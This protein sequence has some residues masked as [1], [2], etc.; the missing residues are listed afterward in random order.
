MLANSQITE[1]LKH[2]PISSAR[3]KK[4]Y[5]KY[6]K[7]NG[8]DASEKKSE[9]LGLAMSPAGAAPPIRVLK[10]YEKMHEAL[11]SWIDYNCDTVFDVRDAHPSK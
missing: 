6:F 11:G 7:K 8:T 9:T 1:R 5:D 3:C 4:I 10:V 2:F